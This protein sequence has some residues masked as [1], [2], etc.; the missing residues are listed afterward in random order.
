MSYRLGVQEES[1]E[2]AWKRQ[3]SGSQ[4]DLKQADG[5]LLSFSSSVNK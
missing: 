4:V 1:G 5:V 2:E 3:G